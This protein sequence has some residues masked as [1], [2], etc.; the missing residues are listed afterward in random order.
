MCSS[1]THEL[2]TMRDAEARMRLQWVIG[3][4]SVV[5][6]VHELQGVFNI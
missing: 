6:L 5:K 1:L 3:Q 4:S 2:Q